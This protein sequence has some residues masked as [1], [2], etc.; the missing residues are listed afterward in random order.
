MHI[1][2]VWSFGFGLMT[3]LRS[4]YVVTDWQIDKL[5]TDV[6]LQAASGNY[7]PVSLAEESAADEPM[8]TE[9][10]QLNYTISA[11]QSDALSP[12]VYFI[13]SYFL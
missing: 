10:D 2:V 5:A 13:V 9:T 3:V 6:V 4:N 11:E 8:S 12:R 7:K 1:V